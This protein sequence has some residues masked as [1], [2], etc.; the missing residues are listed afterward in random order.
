MYESCETCKYDSETDEFLCLTCPSFS[1][2]G[3]YSLLYNGFCYD[4]PDDCSECEYDENSEDKNKLICKACIN[5]KILNESKQCSN[6]NEI[7]ELG[8]GC[9][10]C[11]YN[12]IENKYECYSC[13]DDVDEYYENNY[14]YLNE[15]LQCVRN[16]NKSDIYLYG[17]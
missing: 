6:C 16:D 12:E 11:G 17:C 8:D 10:S 1:D 2:S 9:S 5:G 3:I 13:I 14:I 15:T 7:K 4:C